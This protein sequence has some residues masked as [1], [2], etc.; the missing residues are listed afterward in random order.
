MYTNDNVYI[1]LIVDE[2]SLRIGKSQIIYV[3]IKYILFFN[4]FFKF[5]KVTRLEMTYINTNIIYKILRLN[6][7][8]LTNCQTSSSTVILILKSFICKDKKVE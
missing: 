4:P 3:S 6:K 8:K 1:I 7:L 5:L 2:T